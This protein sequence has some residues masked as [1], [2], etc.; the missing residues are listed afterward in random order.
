M[1][2][3]SKTLADSRLERPSKTPVTS[4]FMRDLLLIVHGRPIDEQL[5]GQVQ[6][7]ARKFVQTN[8]LDKFNRYS[9]TAYV[10]HYIGRDPSTGWEALMMNWTKGNRTTI[11]SHPQFAGY[12]FADG[13]F[14]VE[15]FEPYKNGARLVDQLH[16]TQLH[17]LHAIGQA[18]EFSNHIHRITCLSPTAHSLH[19]YSD[20]ALKGLT[21]DEVK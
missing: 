13:E 6:A 10:R 12:T 5:A 4:D 17:S 19:I 21:Y 16:V 11:H 2:C 20:D 9:A 15:I 1:Q 3:Q 8:P 7:L 18:G 14:C